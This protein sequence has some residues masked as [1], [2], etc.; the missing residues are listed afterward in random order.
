MALR[1]LPALLP[2]SVYKVNKKVFRPTIEEAKKAFIDL[3]PVSMNVE[4]QN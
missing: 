3:L 4:M 1:L 2:P